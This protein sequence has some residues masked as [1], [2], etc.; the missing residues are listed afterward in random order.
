MSARRRLPWGRQPCIGLSLLAMLITTA[1]GDA[2]GT[3]K[4][5][6]ER[7]EAVSSAP[8]VRPQNGAQHTAE[9]PRVGLERQ[10]QAGAS[11]NTNRKEKVGNAFGATSW[12]VPPPPPP[13]PKPLPPPPPTAPPLP[14]SYLGLYQGAP[15]LVIMLV[16]GGLIYTV[17]VGDVIDNTY[18]IDAVEHGKVE[19]TY[20]PL[21]IKQFISTGNPS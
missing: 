7:Q 3:E 21:N 12:Y 15:G 2:R 11:K 14:F 9:E 20:L 1:A 16:R 13:P 18:R 4:T 5:L 6:R 19:I 17:A 10:G 8:A